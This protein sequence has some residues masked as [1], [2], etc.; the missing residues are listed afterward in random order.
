MYFPLYSQITTTFSPNLNWDWLLRILF[1]FVLSVTHPY[2]CALV[3]W[4]IWICFRIKK[5]PVRGAGCYVRELQIPWSIWR[6]YMHRFCCFL[7][8]DLERLKLQ[9]MRNC[10]TQLAI[11]E[12]CYNWL[13]RICFLE[14]WLGGG[15]SLFVQCLTSLNCLKNKNDLNLQLRRLTRGS[16]TVPLCSTTLNI[17]C[18]IETKWSVGSAVYFCFL[19]WASLSEVALCCNLLYLRSSSMWGCTLSICLILSASVWAD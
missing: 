4:L 14:F 8:T 9:T 13:I 18:P 12:K 3:K 2:Q 1:P 6:W 19:F 10:T 7:Y 5:T 16:F 11:K 17:F 15:G